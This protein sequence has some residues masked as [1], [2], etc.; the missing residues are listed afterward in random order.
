M[1]V[2]KSDDMVSSR[3]FPKM[4]VWFD[5]IFVRSY[6]SPIT[7]KGCGGHDPIAETFSE[8]TLQGL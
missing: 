5:S 4:D 7:R 1:V 8:D 2:R 6:E 3:D